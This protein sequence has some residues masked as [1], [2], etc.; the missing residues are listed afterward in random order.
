MYSSLQGPLPEHIPAPAPCLT[1]QQQQLPL[2]QNQTLKDHPC[3]LLYLQILT[4]NGL[5]LLSN[6]SNP[7]TFLLLLLSQAIVISLLSYYK[8]SAFTSLLSGVFE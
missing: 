4:T 5:F 1:E 8:A 6:V 2:Y 3:L 7:P